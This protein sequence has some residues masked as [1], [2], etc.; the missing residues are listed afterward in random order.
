MFT[1]EFF[2]QQRKLL[3]DRKTNKERILKEGGQQALLH[4]VK[5]IQRIIF[6]LRRLDAGQYGICTQC[7]TLIE[8]L[9]LQFM[10]ETPLCSSCARLSTQ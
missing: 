7:G 10:P 5:D 8:L 4:S 3:L 6:A 9:R 1:D 2:D